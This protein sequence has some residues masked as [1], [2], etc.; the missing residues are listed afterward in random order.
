MFKCLGF[1]EYCHIWE[2]YICAFAFP[3]L[4]AH[5]VDLR[6]PVS[7]YVSNLLSFKLSLFV[8]LINYTP[9]PQNNCIYMA[10]TTIFHI[11]NNPSSYFFLQTVRKLCFLWGRD[12]RR[13]SMLENRPWWSK[14]GRG[15]PRAASAWC[16]FNAFTGMLIANVGRVA[17]SRHEF[18]RLHHRELHLHQR[19]HHHQPCHHQCLPGLAW[20]N[21]NAFKGMLIAGAQ[22]PTACPDI[23]NHHALLTYYQQQ[24]PDKTAWQTKP[25]HPLDHDIWLSCPFVKLMKQMRW[26]ERETSCTYKE[27]HQLVMT[28]YFSLLPSCFVVASKGREGR[29]QGILVCG[30]HRYCSPQAPASHRGE[31]RWGWGGGWGGGNFYKLK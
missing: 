4:P 29:R 12:L 10:S 19:R 28:N 8:Y 15:L 22:L 3:S 6:I 14:T 25:F 1:D 21:F 31:L 7:Q 2:T 27:A 5:L 16:N 18:C 24:Q 17:S 20:C 13:E 26:K 11:H 23:P 30:T 9:S